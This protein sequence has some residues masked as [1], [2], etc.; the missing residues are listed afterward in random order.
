MRLG[1]WSGRKAWIGP[2]MARLVAENFALDVPQICVKSD[3]HCELAFFYFALSRR[4]V[5]RLCGS[6]CSFSPNGK[7]FYPFPVL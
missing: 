7:E 4:C 3:R 1:L 2:W 5:H 6:F